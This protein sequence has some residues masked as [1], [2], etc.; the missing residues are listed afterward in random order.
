MKLVIINDKLI[1]Q[2]IAVAIYNTNGMMYMNKGLILNSSNMNKIKKM[3]INTLYVEDGNNDCVLQEAIS[4]LHKITYVKM[5]NNEFLNIKKSRIPNYD[6]I[7]EIING[8]IENINLSENA[9]LF[10]NIGKMDDSLDLAIH[11]IDVAILTIMVAVKKK[12]DQKKVINLGIGALLHDVG[13]LF[14]NDESH[15]K[16][17]YTIIKSNSIFSPTTAMAVAQHHERCDG[18][19]YPEKISK[20]KIFE[21]AKIISICD[22]HVNYSNNENGYLPLEILERITSET[23][24]KFDFQIYEDFK[25]SICC[26]PNGLRVSLSNGN[27]GIVFMQNKNFPLR[28]FVQLDTIS[29]KK[30]INLMKELSIQIN[31]VLIE[32]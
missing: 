19:G 7:Y 5:L 30:Y 26:Y 27:V 2:S 22:S 24:T 6:N 4:P 13:K 20:D 1:G 25:S 16:V 31:T 17:G 3:G 9:F 14:C 10:N 12:Y 18:N 23:N 15:A 29:P 11:S 21:F 32:C 8:L 28:P